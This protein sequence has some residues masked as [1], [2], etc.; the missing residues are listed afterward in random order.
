[1]GV[2]HHT[3][4][5]C[6]GLDLEGMLRAVRRR[7]D[8]LQ[9]D[10]NGNDVIDG[11]WPDETI[12]DYLVEAYEW[13]IQILALNGEGEFQDSYIFDF[14]GGQR[15]YILPADCIR[16][17]RVLRSYRGLYVPL[18]YLKSPT[19]VDGEESAIVNTTH[20]TY[21]LHGM[22]IA[23]SPVPPNDEYQA[24]KLEYIKIPG[25]CKKEGEDS[26]NRPTRQFLP[27]WHRVL[28]LWAT[29]AC[30]HQDRGDAAD[31]EARQDKLALMLVNMSKPRSNQ[32]H[33]VV[34]FD[35]GEDGGAE[36]AFWW[37]N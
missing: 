16:V 27:V 37:G 1:M 14:V 35:G 36:D 30:I 4:E 6:I 28:V 8:A 34:P 2:G 13:C 20:P 15:L 9:T 17:E 24:I 18:E 19:Q 7:I 12:I 22:N 5:S 21:S 10:I 25:M 11:F 23:F 32:R 3:L 29:A 26:G 31:F 33:F